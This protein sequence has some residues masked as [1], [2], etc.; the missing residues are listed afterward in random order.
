LDTTRTNHE[1]NERGS[2]PLRGSNKKQID[3]N[4]K[5]FITDSCL[6]WHAND[7]RNAI[8]MAN[9]IPP[10][11]NDEDCNQMLTKFFSEYRQTIIGEINE[12]MVIWVKENKI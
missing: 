8:E 1:R 3:M 11:L 5:N 7:M 10:S 6:S 12:L 4:N 2:T 9:G